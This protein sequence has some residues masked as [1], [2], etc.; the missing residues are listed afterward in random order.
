[1]KEINENDGDLIVES[2]M[3]GNMKDSSKW[4][5]SFFISILIGWCCVMPII[6]AIRVFFGDYIFPPSKHIPGVSF[7]FIQGE[8]NSTDFKL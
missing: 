4:F 2:K 6:I 1:M 8:N 5:L 3:Y 7:V